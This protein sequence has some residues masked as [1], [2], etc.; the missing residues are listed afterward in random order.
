[1][2]SFAFLL[3]IYY[4]FSS[5]HIS[6]QFIHLI[7]LSFFFLC[8]VCSW[9]CVGLYLSL[10][11]TQYFSLLH[12]LFP[13]VVDIFYYSKIMRGS[14]YCGRSRTVLVCNSCGLF[15]IV[16]EF[17]SRLFNYTDCGM[18]S[19]IYYLA[20][21]LIILLLAFEKIKVLFVVVAEFSE[22]H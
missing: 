9:V 5:F 2:W 21:E 6:I 18:R 4:F 20:K 12:L 14:L 13:A 3:W 7:T 10:C 22:S 17:V 19:W 1:M 16:L 8:I 11:R 15:K